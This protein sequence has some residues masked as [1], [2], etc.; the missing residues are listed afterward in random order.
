[1]ILLKTNT[2]YIY[3]LEKNV[4]N[5]AKKVLKSAYIGVEECFLQ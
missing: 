2:V 1:M 5:R 4:S 3:I